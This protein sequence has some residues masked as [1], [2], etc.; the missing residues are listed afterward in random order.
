MTKVRGQRGVTDLLSVYPYQE[1]GL[2]LVYN[3]AIQYSEQDYLSDPE[4]Y[5]KV[6]DHINNQYI[7]YLKSKNKFEEEYEME[8][9]IDN[10]DFDDY[11][12]TL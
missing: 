3:P 6:V 9:E 12:K 10:K 5:K 8:L 7:D 11:L 1:T 4:T 2:G